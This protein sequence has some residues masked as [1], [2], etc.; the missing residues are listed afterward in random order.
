[1]ESVNKAKIDDIIRNAD[2]IAEKKVKDSEDRIKKENI[3]L[4]Q[5]LEIHQK[6][7]E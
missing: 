4:K 1:M 6:E 7:L 3:K 5:E 2:K